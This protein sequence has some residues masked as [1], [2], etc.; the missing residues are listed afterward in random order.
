MR[1][2]DPG[3]AGRRAE[4]RPNPP[5]IRNAEAVCRCWPMCVDLST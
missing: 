5:N 4:G 2:I 3:S 1:L